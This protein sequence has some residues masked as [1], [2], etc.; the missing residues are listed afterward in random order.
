MR[1][2]IEY[3]GTT[4]RKRR[5][6]NL[7]T[8]RKSR[9]LALKRRRQR[10]ASVADALGLTPTRDQS[11]GDDL[12]QMAAEQL[13]LAAAENDVRQTG[14]AKKRSK[15][16]KGKGDDQDL[17]DY[18]KSLFNTPVGSKD[19]FQSTEESDLTE[20]PNTEDRRFIKDNDASDSDGEYVPTDPGELSSDFDR[21][22]SFGRS[23]VARRE[24]FFSLETK[25]DEGHYRE[26]DTKVGDAEASN[27]ARSTGGKEGVSYPFSPPE[28]HRKETNSGAPLRRQST[29]QFQY[30]SDRDLQHSNTHVNSSDTP[31]SK[32]RTH[33][34]PNTQEV[35]AMGEVDTYDPDAS[36][37]EYLGTRKGMREGEV[38]TH[39]PYK[40]RLSA[41]PAK[42]KRGNTTPKTNNGDK[43]YHRDVN[44]DKTRVPKRGTRVDKHGSQRDKRKEGKESDYLPEDDEIGGEE[45]PDGAAEA[46]GGDGPPEDPSDGS[47]DEDD[48]GSSRG[49]SEKD[50]TSDPDD[51]SEEY[52]RKANELQRKY[53]E[54]KRRKK[55]RRRRQQAN[56][57]PAHRKHQSKKRDKKHPKNRR[58]ERRKYTQDLYDTPVSDEGS[59][60]DD[61]YYYA[62]EVFTASS[63]RV[64]DPYDL[65]GIVAP[66][67]NYGDDATRETFRVKYL[68]YVTKHKAKM[69][70]RAPRD[71]VLPQSV[72]ECMRPSL[73]AYVCKHL[74]APKYQ[75][76]NPES[77]GA[78][79]VHR[80]AMRRTKRT[81]AA[82]NNKGIKE[83]K[84]LKIS[85]TGKDGVKNVQKAFMDLAEIR[86]KYRLA[87][88]EKEIIKWLTWN[89][90]PERAR[91][92]VQN[93]LKEE[94]EDARKAGRQV[95]EYH[96]LIM[97][98]AEQFEGAYRLGMG[99]KARKPKSQRNVDK[100]KGN[101][102]RTR[103]RQPG[104][105]R[106]SNKSRDGD[107][108]DE[109]TTNPKM[110]PCVWCN[111]LH[112]LNKCPTL[113]EE[114]KKWPW[115]KVLK[116]RRRREKEGRE[117][118]NNDTRKVRFK[119]NRRPRG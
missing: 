95:K 13:A 78:L 9:R 85:L 63:A 104:N 116:E 24:D 53:E 109:G 115:Y 47:D 101:K 16:R 18:T 110:R 40:H 93:Y 86:R 103:S 14:K 99:E 2:N 82:E 73:L 21:S 51:S 68:D 4:A 119:K 96:D 112:Y 46:G 72:V 56:K 42:S 10:R 84:A 60:P 25:N 92:T 26:L 19:P 45:L 87:T 106:D 29:P 5:E 105:G 108:G 74:L 35:R 88:S 97:G 3:V 59:E 61:Q 100:N 80:W 107:E 33:H 44:Y 49:G 114:M 11:I 39:D 1:N 31:R 69:R 32:G 81:V 7:R 37:V 102:D 66:Q 50:E 67:L 17:F 41:K 118:G 113:P 98:M 57:Q 70:K 75:T 111:K 77:V 34:K 27:G 43:D 71:R 12:H 89:V 58:A 90:T 94:G 28:L 83:I 23:R 76:D 55:E 8:V 91:L 6:S 48:E 65:K 38:D 30:D 62:P 79:V 64:Y 15:G 117:S 52:R 54:H 36:S 20:E 22:N